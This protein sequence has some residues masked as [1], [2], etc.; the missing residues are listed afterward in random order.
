MDAP[1]FQIDAFTSKRFAGN[2]AAVVPL[3]EWLPDE[4]LRA[5]AMENNLSETAYFTEQQAGRYHLR[6]FTPAREVDLC[7]HATLATA[8]VIFAHY[9]PW[10]EK[11]HFNTLSGELS[12]E[13]RDGRYWLDFPARAAQVW[14]DMGC[15]EAALRAKPAQVLRTRLANPDSDKVVAVF[16]NAEAVASLEP[17]FVALLAVE[18]QGVVATAPGDD[19]ADFVSRY[20]VPKLGI[21]EDPVTGSTH[22]SLVPYWAER[23]DKTSLNARQLSPRGGELVCELK[24]ERVLIGGEAVQYLEGRISV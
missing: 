22:T 19:D 15:V 9:A 18:G 10:L 21:A 24:G 16:E 11:L 5:I 20:F 13:R 6:W 4:T 14:N 1:I 7:G 23:L 17:D 12:V 3:S 8:F 2:P